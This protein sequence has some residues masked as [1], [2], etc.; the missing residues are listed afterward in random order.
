M[1][2]L[3]KQT[4]LFTGDSC[5]SRIMSPAPAVKCQSIP[6]INTL[7]RHNKQYLIDIL[8]NTWLTLLYT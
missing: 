1:K 4:A 7:D 6:S 8:I 5:L 3:T 2:V